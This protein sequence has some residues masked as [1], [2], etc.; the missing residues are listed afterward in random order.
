M[1]DLIQFVKEYGHPAIVLIQMITFGILT[2]IAFNDLPHI[3]RDIRDLAERISNLEG[4]LK[5]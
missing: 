2:K 3:E 5:K 4:R 1:I